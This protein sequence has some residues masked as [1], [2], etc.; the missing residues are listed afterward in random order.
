MDALLQRS[1]LTSCSHFIPA[2]HISLQWKLNFN[3]KT[4]TGLKR[5]DVITKAGEM[6]E[7][8][9]T[10]KNADLVVGMELYKVSKDEP[11]L[12]LHA[13]HTIDTFD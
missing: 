1:P 8:P 6:S 5:L 12:D 3:S 2:H 9:V 10:M 11:L 13:C 4:D 7:L